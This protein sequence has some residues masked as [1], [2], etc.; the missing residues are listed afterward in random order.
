MSYILE[1]LKKAEQARFAAK[2]PNI[3]SLA[4]SS[5]EPVRERLAWLIGAMLVTAL[6]SAAAMGWWFS[7]TA[8]ERPAPEKV[9]IISPL[10]PLTPMAVDA[11]REEVAKPNPRKVDAAALAGSR[12]D[13]DLHNDNNVAPGVLPISTP[14]QVVAPLVVVRPV[15]SSQGGAYSKPRD[16]VQQADKSAG[17]VGSPEQRPAAKPSEQP[18]PAP[19]QKAGPKRADRPVATAAVESTELM[20]IDLKP[21]R[22]TRVLHVEE[23]PSEVRRDVP[24][25]S[26]TGYV[27]SADTGVR[28]VNVNERSLQEGDELMAGLKLELIAP[29]HVLF[30][31]RGYRFRVEMF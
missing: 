15:T 30:S 29:D 25:I 4:L 7:G 28:V 18:S 22:S 2:L 3:Q 23:L 13:N 19:G 6:A 14:E 1:A 16:S 31:F 10:T 27:Y 8:H 20:P 24:K 26:A 12:R 21:S 5:D 11:A 9:A 17:F